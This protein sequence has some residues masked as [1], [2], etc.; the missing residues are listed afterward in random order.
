MKFAFIQKNLQAYPVEAVCDVLDV[1]RSGYYAW[2]DRTPSSRAKRRRQLVEK[3][4][5]IHEENRQVYGSPRVCRASSR[6]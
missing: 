3:I 6:P 5:A 1:S 4:K 2:R